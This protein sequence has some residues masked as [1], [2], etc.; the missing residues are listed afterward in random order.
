MENLFEKRDESTNIVVSAKRRFGMAFSKIKNHGELEY[1]YRLIAVSVVQASLTSGVLVYG[2][3]NTAIGK[4]MDEVTDEVREMVIIDAPLF[5]NVL[6]KVVKNYTG[7]GNLR[8][9]HQASVESLL[10][11]DFSYDES[12]FDILTTTSDKEEYLRYIRNIL[13]IITPKHKG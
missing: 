3:D 2:C 13:D 7:Y 12:K 5:K 8:G 1:G 6:M 9:F 4:F 11:E 10:G